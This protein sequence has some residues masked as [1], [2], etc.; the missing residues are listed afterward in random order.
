MNYDLLTLCY[1]R[2]K[3]CLRERFLPIEVHC[4]R[5]MSVAP[6]RIT[7]D[8]DKRHTRVEQ[9]FSTQRIDRSGTGNFNR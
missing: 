1:H 7:S 2:Q 4:T 9:F 6:I 5:N 8:V 3:G